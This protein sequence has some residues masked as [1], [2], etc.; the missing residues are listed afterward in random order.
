[1]NIHN[2]GF[3][4]ADPLLCFLLRSETGGEGDMEGCWP[5]SE[6]GPAPANLVFN[7]FGT[8]P[9][10]YPCFLVSVLSQ[11]GCVSAG[12]LEVMPQRGR[13]VGRGEAVVEGEDVNA[14]DVVFQQLSGLINGRGDAGH[15]LIGRA[16]GEGHQQSG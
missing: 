13:H 3:L 15:L 6:G 1:M 16:V 7:S 12:L 5:C 4:G 8:H 11:Q 9:K 2:S 10:F 14:G